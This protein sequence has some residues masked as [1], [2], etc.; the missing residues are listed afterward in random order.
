MMTVR[1]E[2][3]HVVTVDNARAV[4]MIEQ[5]ATQVDPAELETAQAQAEVETA[6]VPVK[7]APRKRSASKG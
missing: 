1:L 6:E 5:G 4:V 7:R 3:G 2:S